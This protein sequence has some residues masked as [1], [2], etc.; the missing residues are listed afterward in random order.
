MINKLISLANY[1]D[2]SSFKKEADNVDLLIKIAGMLDDAIRKNP[3]LEASIRN[4]HA[5]V[6]PGHFR[7]ALEE[8]VD[9][10]ATP[11][12]L[13]PLLNRFQKIR[14]NLER[15]DLYQYPAI[16]ILQKAIKAHGQTDVEARKEKREKRYRESDA[17]H[18][19][20]YAVTCT[21]SRTL[22]LIYCVLENIKT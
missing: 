17:Y 22:R 6:R 14:N 2:R 10:N 12:E 1:L 7:W 19:P 16:N 5:G 4:L 21:F 9:G 18:S 11:E 13:V 15:G 20:E 8:V 3:E